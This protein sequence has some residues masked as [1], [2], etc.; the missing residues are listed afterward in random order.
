MLEKNE[1][2][3][4]TKQPRCTPELTQKALSL[5]ETLKTLSQTIRE[6][7]LDAPD[8]PKLTQLILE[9]GNCIGTLMTLPILELPGETQDQL[10]ETLLLCQ[11]WDKEIQPRMASFKEQTGTQLQDMK[12]TFALANKYRSAPREQSTRTEKA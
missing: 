2:E 11:Q 8:F 1:T 4:G 3:T 5:I 7:N 9:R 6:H 10:R 12:A